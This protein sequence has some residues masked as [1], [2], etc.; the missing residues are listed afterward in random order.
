MTL[1]TRRTALTLAAGSLAAGSTVSRRASAAI[2]I[3]DVPP[4]KLELEKGASL[5]VL[6]PAK[7]IEPDERWFRANTK[8][9]TEATGIPVR[10]DFVG[11]EDLRPQT[12]V[13]ANTGAGPDIIIGWPDDPHLYTSKLIELT[14]LAEY[15]GAKYGGWY[16]L[17]QRY[18]KQW[19]TD[20]WISLPI[21]GSSGPIVYRISWVKEAGFET[22]P[23]DLDQFL[24]LCRKL[25]ANGHPAG[26][27]LGNSVG[28]AAGYAHWLL[29]SHGGYIVDEEG[30]VAL[31]RPETIAALKY[32]KE[33]QKTF[34]P[35]TLS[36]LDPSNNKAFASGDISLTAN[37]VSIYYALKQ[38]PKTAAM[39]EDTG[40]AP[41]P[42]GVVGKP[43]MS[44]AMLNAMVFR[45]TRYPNVAKDY[46]RFIM[47][48]EQYE[49]WLNDCL[50]YWAQ[51]LKAYANCPVWTSDPKLAIY[52]D[53]CGNEFWNGYKGPITAASS[54]VTAEYVLVHMF[55]AVVSDSATPEDAVR[56]AVRR[57]RRYYKG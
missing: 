27:A 42:F 21:G 40:H 46:L 29:W 57:A 53:G 31:N 34:I 35:G 16:F 30:H 4:I 24:A 26:F 45:H 2:P 7:F 3:A 9:Y 47:E 11:W 38:D 49:P 37:G 15:L 56:E 41:L 52:R 54:A 18:G 44:S 8:K 39:A 19:G 55:A 28:D 33:L 6:R 32:G 10:V 50:G 5:R 36:W 43:P 14:D 48:V 13:S 51:P 17:P 20:R 23:T 25:K 1:I 22:I 12:A